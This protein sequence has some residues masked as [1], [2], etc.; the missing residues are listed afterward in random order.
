MVLPMMTKDLVK[1]QLTNILYSPQLCYT[2]ISIAKIND[3]GYLTTFADGRCEIHNRAGIMLV[4]V[5]KTQRLYHAASTVKNDLCRAA[6]SDNVTKLT[7]ME[8][9]RRMGHVVP[10]AACRLV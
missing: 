2:L 9:H 7:L 3:A 10:N 4:N 5:P 6:S 8:L 1:F